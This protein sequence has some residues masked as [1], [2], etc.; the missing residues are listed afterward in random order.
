MEKI[1]K[2]EFDTLLSSI[3]IEEGYELKIEEKDG[4][5]YINLLFSG[6]DLGYLIGN[7]GKHL[8]SLQYIFSMILRKKLPEDTN[9]RVLLDVCGYKEE[10]N[11]KLERFALQKADD[12]RILGDSVELPAMSPSDRRVV[13]VAL[14]MFDD[15]KTESI[16]EGEDRRIVITPIES[17]EADNILDESEEESEE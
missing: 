1:V 7:H 5:S 16:G 6:E 14:Q 9:Y 12:A 3:G 4:V 17:K 10:R 8:E 2:K 15:I 13:H 11:K